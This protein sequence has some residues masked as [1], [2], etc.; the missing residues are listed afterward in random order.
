MPRGKAPLVY[1]KWLE[2]YGPLTW[3]VASGKQYLI[4]NDYHMMKELLEKR[5]NI[6]IDRDSLV[7][8][9]QII[10]TVIS[11]VEFCSTGTHP[12]LS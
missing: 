5:G 2:Q 8:L 9:G 6:Y 3:V 7:L 4:V 12:I 1:L 11:E 10:G